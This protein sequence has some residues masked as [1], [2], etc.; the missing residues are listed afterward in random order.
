[1]ENSIVPQILEEVK[2][3]ESE[4]RFIPAS[5]IDP[6]SV[7]HN[8]QIYMIEK[9]SPGYT[10]IYKLTREFDYVVDLCARALQTDNQNIRLGRSEVRHG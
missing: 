7:D 1:M 2:Q 9:G 4:N 8:R 5:S 3:I 6:P 10:A